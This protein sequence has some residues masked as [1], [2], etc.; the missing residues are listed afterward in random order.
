MTVAH[1]ILGWFTM[2][3]TITAVAL[4]WVVW[5]DRRGLTA[6]H[7]QIADLEALWALPARERVL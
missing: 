6:Q 2:G 5:D 4:A 1:L 7:R 3:A